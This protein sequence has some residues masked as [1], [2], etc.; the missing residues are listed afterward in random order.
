M[1]IYRSDNPTKDGR[2]WYYRCFY[3]NIYGERK[4]RKSKKYKLKSEAQEAERLFL[5]RSQD[6]DYSKYTIKDC[7]N[8]FI[9]NYD[10][11]YKNTTIFN[12]KSRQKYFEQLFRI[13]LSV[14]NIKHIEDWKSYLN[15]HTKLSINSKNAIL[16]NVKTVLTNFCNKNNVHLN[17][18]VRQIENF[19]D[20]NEI[21]KPLEIYTYKEF[22]KFIKNADNL[23]LKALFMTF[24]FCGL[25]M[26]E[27]RAL[28][29]SDI[30][31]KNK[32]LNIS[33]QIPTG[34]NFITPPKT[35]A[36]IRQIPIPDALLEEL[37]KLHDYY[38]TFYKFN[39]NWY[40]FGGNQPISI[41]EIKKENKR[42]SKLAKLKT[43]NIHSF[44]HSC[45]SLLINNNAN[46]TIIAQYL[47][48][49]NIT[50]TLN[51]Y[52]HMFKSTLNE[53][54]DKINKL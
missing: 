43:I 2:S 33:K 15:K 26:G 45:V 24:Y 16:S 5:S 42:L 21:T 8:F 12:V 28:Q 23:N 10:N 29:W 3:E 20:P 11:K 54:V 7:Y 35:R 32:N 46:I 4:Q 27:I 18:N 9:A 30:N 51:T 37:S 47:G 22:S 53:V 48:H 50:T 6:Y 38:S 25:R 17:F 49:H 14:L 41:Y 13:K 40:V 52:S 34:Y 1:P 39:Q 19:K 36:G 31:F 44:R